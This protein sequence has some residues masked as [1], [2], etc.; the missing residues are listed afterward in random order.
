MGLP[1]QV[2]PQPPFLTR[3]TIRVFSQSKQDSFGPVSASL[4]LTLALALALALCTVTFSS[5]I[6][7]YPDSTFTAFNSHQS[8][9]LFAEV[10]PR[11]AF[12][13]FP[14]ISSFVNKLWHRYSFY[15]WATGCKPTSSAT[16]TTGFVT[17][18]VRSIEP[19][20]L[21]ALWMSDLCCL[22]PRSRP[23]SLSMAV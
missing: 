22:L 23:S 21:E 17:R 16:Y 18:L 3:K 12:T 15:V 4:A 7:Y 2:R 19:F 10:S 8:K 1:A 13:I 20:K 5:T 6:S 14:S 11:L 9:C